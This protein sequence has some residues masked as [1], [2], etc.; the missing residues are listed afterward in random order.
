MFVKK[1]EKQ[2]KLIQVMF[3]PLSLTQCFQS[4]KISLPY[5]PSQQSTKKCHVKERDTWFCFSRNREKSFKKSQIGLAFFSKKT[6]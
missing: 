6:L 4:S 3:G 5:K 1:Y 2:K